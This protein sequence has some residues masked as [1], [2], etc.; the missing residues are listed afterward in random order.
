[1]TRGLYS[2]LLRIAL[3]FAVLAF[4][5]RGWRSPAY[6][7]S[8]RERLG[9]SMKTRADRPLWLH[10]SSVGE[11]RALAVLVRA[12]HRQEW[13]L[14]VTVGTPVGLGRARELFADLCAPAGEAF[15]LQAAPWDL[16]G[17]ARRFLEA[18]RP[19]GAIF[20]ETELWPNLV[21][22]ADRA[23][24][25]LVLVSARL[26]TRSLSRY[27]RFAPRLMR[28]TVRAVTA[29]GAQTEVDR[30]RFIQLGSD[31]ATVTVMGNLKFDLTV[32]AAICA[33]G[34]RLREQWA[35][36]RPLW[37]AGSTHPGEE[38]DCIAAHHELLRR[39]RAA[40]RALPQ[41]ALAPRRPERFA[42]VAQWL[43][44]QELQVA[45]S[46]RGVSSSADIVLIDEMGMLMDWYAAGDA[47]F[48]G[49]S[50]VPVGGHN[51]LEPAAVGR[52]VLAG[53]HQFNAPDVAAK[54]LET[55]GL[56]IVANA[57]DLATALDALFEDSTLAR[58]RGEH[59]ADAVAANRG[60]ALRARAMISELMGAGTRAQ[61]AA[62]ASD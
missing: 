56:Q 7:G 3:P 1:M 11:V 61:A 10:A 54:L 25:P 30:S 53:P 19:R 32:D 6:R 39:A 42:A 41:L 16:P 51:L 13:P 23:R 55:G 43:A 59:A 50:L 22:A 62:P 52:P 48:V 34:A 14:L 4:L 2:L 12:L 20:M 46:S 49:G 9:L 58:D 40:G 33:R 24:L 38:A 18:S 57:Q 21:G 27:L 31:P 45:L 28:N 17:A 47:A 5:W 44:A 37:V 36:G 60:A 15:T 8:L 29:I 26:S 35:Q